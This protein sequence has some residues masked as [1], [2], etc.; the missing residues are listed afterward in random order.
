[1]KGDRLD[2]TG[3]GVFA[4]EC[5]DKCE[6]FD[7]ENVDEGPGGGVEKI[8]VNREGGDVESMRF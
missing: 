7:I 2:G 5:V 3:C 1:M 8:F 4:V 6:C